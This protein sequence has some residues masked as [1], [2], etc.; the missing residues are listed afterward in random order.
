M[1]AAILP[2]RA[3]LLTDAAELL[4]LL[5][6]VERAHLLDED[7]RV[8]LLLGQ[9]TASACEGLAAELVAAASVERG[10]SGSLPRGG[11]FPSGAHRQ[12]S[13]GVARPVEASAHLLQSPPSDRGVVEGSP[14][15]GPTTEQADARPLAPVVPLAIARSVRDNP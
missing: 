11:S 9:V 13:A 15:P 12:T 2:P 6:A 3:T 7:E 5:A 8:T 10:G 4:R 1:G 14:S